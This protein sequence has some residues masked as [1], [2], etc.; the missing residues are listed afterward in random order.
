MTNKA[1]YLTFSVAAISFATL[2][3]AAELELCGNMVQGGLV[4]GQ[5][6]N[7][8]SVTQNGKNIPITNDGNFLLAFDRDAKSTQELVL[9]YQDG[10]EEKYHLNIAPTK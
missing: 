1:I 5:A 9:K 3:N 7:L 8:Q 6:K 10:Q 2:A 4:K